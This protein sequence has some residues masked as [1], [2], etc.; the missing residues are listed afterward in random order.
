M[1]RVKPW[2]LRL[3]T[4]PWQWVTIWP[5]I[6]RP[7]DRL[8]EHYPAIV[9][10]EQVHLAQQASVNR[11]RWIWTYLMNRRFRLEME[12]RAIAA[13]VRAHSPVM[14]ESIIRAYALQLSG[15]DYRHAAASYE[16]A[17]S[18]IRFALEMLP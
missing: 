3:I 5:H 6:Y 17:V 11:W 8:P 9:I 16:D 18:A 10:H 7:S 15:P 4:K 2:W 13:E 1:I 12:A 14:R